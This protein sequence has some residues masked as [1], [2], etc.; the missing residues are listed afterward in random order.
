MM[1]AM[2]IQTMT[3]L[4]LGETSADI[5]SFYI[6]LCW[7]SIIMIVDYWLLVTSRMMTTVSVH[8]SRN[9]DDGNG[10]PND[11]KADLGVTSADKG[12]KEKWPS[13]TNWC[14]IADLTVMI[15]MMVIM[16]MIMTII[17]IMMVSMA[18]LSAVTS[19]VLVKT[20][21]LQT[22]YFNQD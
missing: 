8:C 2:A 5:D 6:I 3:R 10:N 20:M 7:I 21:F 13:W 22:W 17:L 19:A 18:I 9:D 12:D 16:T 11:D 4:C 15:M 1:I 14:R